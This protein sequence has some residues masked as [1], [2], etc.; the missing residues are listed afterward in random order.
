[1]NGEPTGG[2]SI[3]TQSR[4]GSHARA[5]LWFEAGASATER[6]VAAQ[7]KSKEAADTYAD[8]R[9]AHVAAYQARLLG[10]GN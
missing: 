7:L 1:M 9:D 4:F 2:R 5:S 3:S 8:E 6:R 10:G